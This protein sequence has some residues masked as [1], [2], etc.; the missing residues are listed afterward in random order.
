[1]L[2]C[3]LIKIKYNQGWNLYTDYPDFA[4]EIML[5]MHGLN[6]VC[7][8]YNS[9]IFYVSISLLDNSFRIVQSE[10]SEMFDLLHQIVDKASGQAIY[11]RLV[12]NYIL[13]IDC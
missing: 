9:Y 8:K 1:V 3:N 4:L 7:F 6:H 13:K 10:M 5:P 11:W 2:G 12:Q